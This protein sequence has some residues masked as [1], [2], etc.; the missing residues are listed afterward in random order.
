[1]KAG[2]GIIIALGITCIVLA[3]GL[4]GVIDSKNSQIGDLQDQL[5]VKNSQIGICNA[6]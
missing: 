2:K 4:V 5:R 6:K 3:V 1:M